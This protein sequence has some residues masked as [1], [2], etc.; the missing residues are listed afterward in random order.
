[1]GW[2]GVGVAV[3]G[4]GLGIIVDFGSVAVVRAVGVDAEGDDVSD[5]GDGLGEMVGIGSVAVASTGI[6]GDGM[7]TAVW[8]GADVDAGAQALRKSSPIERSCCH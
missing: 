1:M 6:E 3:T 8:V 2:V 4:I 7:D 5:T